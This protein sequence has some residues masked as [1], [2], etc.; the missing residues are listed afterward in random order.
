MLD[1]LAREWDPPLKQ[2]VICLRSNIRRRIYA[3]I[4]CFALMELMIPS[5]SH[6]YFESYRVFVMD[7][8]STIFTQSLT[9]LP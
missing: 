4:F 8:L 7:F 9:L 5:P 3:D 6:D 1:S 2:L